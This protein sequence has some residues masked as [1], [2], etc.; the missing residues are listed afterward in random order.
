MKQSSVGRPH[1]C[2]RVG[3]VP[4]VT[5][6]KPCGVPLDLRTEV[7]LSVDELEALDLADLRGLHHA[8]AGEQMGISRA[9]FGRI[10][11]SARRKVVLSLRNGFSL[12]IE[13]GTYEVVMTRN[14]VCADCGHRW[15]SQQGRCHTPGCPQ[16]G[17]QQFG[18]DHHVRTGQEKESGGCCGDASHHHQEGGGCDR[19]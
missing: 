18:C 2:R 11:E 6:F 14:F 12:R 15:E 8:Q 19:Q 13:G 10:L 4:I 17:S 16:C 3:S 9:T 7:S 1:Q 5:R